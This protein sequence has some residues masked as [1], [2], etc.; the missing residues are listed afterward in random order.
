MLINLSLSL[1][2][3]SKRRNEFRYCSRPVSKTTSREFVIWFESFTSFRQNHEIVEISLLGAKEDR[4]II[5]INTFRLNKEFDR[6]YSFTSSSSFLSGDVDSLAES[7]RGKLAKIRLRASFQIYSPKLGTRRVKCDRNDC[8]K[9]RIRG[10][11]WIENNCNVF[12]NFF[13]IVM[14]NRYYSNFQNFGKSV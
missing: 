1:L 9:M 3:S 7:G 6:N 11:V 10:R 12:T 8:L 2:I 14:K 4:S 13:T 5:S